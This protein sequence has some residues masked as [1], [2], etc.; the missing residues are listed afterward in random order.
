MNPVLEG[1]PIAAPLDGYADLC[2][3]ALYRVGEVDVRLEGLNVFSIPDE[4]DINRMPRLMTT[5]GADLAP[6]FAK[7]PLLLFR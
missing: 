4:T 2:C 7:H 1:L 3:D 5:A 6:A